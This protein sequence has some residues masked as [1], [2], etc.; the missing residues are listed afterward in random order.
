MKQTNGVPKFPLR[1]MVSL[2]NSDVLL[3]VVCGIASNPRRYGVETRAK[4]AKL[5]R[6][7]SQVEILA[8]ARIWFVVWL[9]ESELKL[10]KCAVS[11]FPLG[12]LPMPVLA[13]VFLHLTLVDAA[14]VARSSSRFNAAFQDESTWFLRCLRD[15]STPP[16]PIVAGS[17][18]ETYKANCSPG[19]KPRIQVP[20]WTGRKG[21]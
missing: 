2:V 12:Q 6:L 21:F 17:W 15:I 14:Y 1:S 10:Y 4:Q 19:R 9:P 13:R 7:C 5:S 11:S 3:G 8:I 20:R 16:P 18:K